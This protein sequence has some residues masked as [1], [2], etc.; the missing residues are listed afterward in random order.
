[1]KLFLQF[2][3]TRSFQDRY[4]R[5]RHTFIAPRA[6]IVPIS[7]STF[8]HRCSEMCLSTIVILDLSSK[9]VQSMLSHIEPQCAS[10]RDTGTIRQVWGYAP[11]GYAGPGRNHSLSHTIRVW[12][13]ASIT[14]VPVS[15]TIT[16]A[17]TDFISST[18][19]RPAVQTRFIVATEDAN[20]FDALQH[21]VSGSGHVCSVVTNLEDLS[22][23]IA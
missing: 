4:G 5:F 23:G 14:P 3:L 1:M 6:S 15:S 19:T 20:A 9:T 22:A 12:G 8:E 13:E 17:V 21:F 7:V 18:Q 11:R 16:Q 10:M 2:I